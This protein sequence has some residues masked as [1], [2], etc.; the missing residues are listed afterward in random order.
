LSIAETSP[1]EPFRAGPP[2]GHAP[3]R[4]PPHLT[5][6]VLDAASCM[7][8]VTEAGTGVILD[9]NSAAERLMGFARDQ[10]I[11]LRLW[12]LAAPAQQAMLRRALE[13]PDSE[14]LPMSFESTVNLRNG[15]PTRIVWSSD[16]ITD[17]AGIQTHVVITGVDMTSA[18]AGGL[19]GHVVRAA[20]VTALIST[21]RRGRVT[22]C[23]SG[24]E[25][26][27]GYS[28]A[29]LVGQLLPQGLFDPA[30]FQ[31]RAEALAMPADL[32]LLT[33]TDRR[34]ERRTGPRVDLGAGD[35]RRP[36]SDARREA[37]RAGGES[38]ENRDWTLVRKDGTRLIA[39]VAIS[40]VNDAAGRH[41]GY[42]GV[43]HDVTE[44]REANR[45]L[46]VA[47]ANEGKA[48]RR[49]QDLDR[50]KS[51][52][53]AT[54][55]H[56]LRTPTTSIAGY[57]ELLE[58]GFAG[59]LS[60]AQLELVQTVRRNTTRLAG[61]AEDLLTLTQVDEGEMALDLVELDLREVVNRA[62]ETMRALLVDR[63]LDN[64][65]EVPD[66]PVMVS[67]DARHLDQVVSNLI[68]NAIKF[69]DDG[70]DISCLLT[71]DEG[72][73]VLRVSD[74]GI[75]I[76]IP[77]QSEV[78][79]RFFRSSTAQ[80]RAIQGIGLGLSIAASI[81]HAHGGQISVDSEH[82][83]GTTFTVRIP[84]AVPEPTAAPVTA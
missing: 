28:E 73:A 67:G 50:I 60:P 29:E 46:S 69:T 66:L 83:Q 5:E 4:L 44:R 51:E 65:V 52:F 19:L 3:T 43:A 64:M 72:E 9:L 33:V 16:F 58:D 8:I 15:T 14:G 71:V 76:P 23:S 78:F 31:A 81:I 39:S 49:L 80:A 38:L 35:R 2:P 63:C 59:E 42:L 53:A 55:S 11:G 6:S 68:S 70:G 32:R 48:L 18:A 41:V 34:I 56:E 84:L 45:L 21:D 30:E 47:L 82:M 36:G 74:T 20:N 37:K 12:D 57:L 61:L 79:T 40:V 62:E 25:Q 77:E 24:A 7:V 1:A 26:M 13:G 22:Y 10:V 27:L 75:G 54:V 17:D